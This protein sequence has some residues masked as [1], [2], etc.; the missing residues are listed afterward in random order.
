MPLLDREVQAAPLHVDAGDP[1]LDPA[2]DRQ[3]RGQLLRDGLAVQ[4]AHGLVAAAAGRVDL[5]EDAPLG[6][7][8]DLPLKPLVRGDALEADRR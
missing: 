4:H 5:H 2:A 6:H 3:A 7:A 8:L 1:D